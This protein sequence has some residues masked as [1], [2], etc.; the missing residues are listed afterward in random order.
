MIELQNP[1]HSYFIG[2]FVTD[3]TFYE[4]SRNRGR[5]S[6]ELS[7]RDVDILVKFSELFD[8]NFTLTGRTR[9]TNFSENFTGS[10]LHFYDLDFRNEL[11]NLGFKAGKKS[12]KIIIPKNIKEIDFM[13]GIIDGDGSLG[14]TKENIPY[15]SFTTQSENLAYFYIYFIKK[16]LN[17]TRTTSRNKR[18]G[19]FSI[20][21][22]NEDT[23]TLSK[24]LY[25][26]NCLCLERKEKIKNDIL[27]WKRPPNKKKINRN[28]WTRE[29]IEYILNHNIQESMIYLNRSDK[30]IKIK[31]FRLKHQ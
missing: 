7:N 6:F 4:Q 31:L 10:I 27:K 24:I 19:M 11:K 28:N 30:S 16:Y 17:K 1:K 22:T 12:D 2:F 9:D 26:N 20:L 15:I 14:F 23:Q 3:G 21:L 8:I 18:D 13:R 5:V 25:Y 29:E